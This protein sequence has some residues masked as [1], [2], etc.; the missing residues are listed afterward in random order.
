METK[1]RTSNTDPK[2][3]TFVNKETTTTILNAIQ[4]ALRQNQEGILDHSRTINK[5]KNCLDRFEL[6][7][8]PNIPGILLKELANWVRDTLDIGP[9]ALGELCNELYDVYSMSVSTDV[10]IKRRSF[11]EALVYV[12]KV[13]FGP[14]YVVYIKKRPGSIT[15]R[16]FKKTSSSKT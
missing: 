13:E 1:L 12:L 9:H 5:I 4:D 8:R 14:Y 7:E 3:F 11:P 6:P 2:S 10:K 15:N 16:S